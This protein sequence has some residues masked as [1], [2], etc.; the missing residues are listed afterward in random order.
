MDAPSEA[1][2]CEE[3][4]KSSIP[5]NV[6]RYHE[7]NEYKLEG[8]S[9]RLQQKETKKSNGIR[10]SYESVSHE[11]IVEVTLEDLDLE[12]NEKKLEV[13]LDGAIGDAGDENE[14][15]AAKEA[16]QQHNISACHHSAE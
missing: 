5:V 1:S 15:V 14:L 3:N 11:N 4:E 9:L 8:T 16:C 13:A 6:S 12:K 10:E 2:E 7:V